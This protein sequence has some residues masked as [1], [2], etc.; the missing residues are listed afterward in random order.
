MVKIT[1]E[2]PYAPTVFHKGMSWYFCLHGIQYGLM[3]VRDDTNNPP[4]A[5]NLS[6]NHVHEKV[7]VHVVLLLHKSKGKRDQSVVCVT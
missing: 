3:P 6:P 1:R 5:N 2:M 4:R 7:P